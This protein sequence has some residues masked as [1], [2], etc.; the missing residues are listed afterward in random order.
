MKPNRICFNFFLIGILTISTGL[1]ASDSSSFKDQLTDSSYKLICEGY[2]NN[3][4]EIFIMDA[5][6]ANLK[7]LT[8]TPD[9]H[10]LYPQV[11]AD[12]KKIAYV[13]DK[14]K[15]RTRIRS[16]WI[17]DINGKNRI[18][19]ADYAR[20]PFWMPDNKELGFLNQEYKKFNVMDFATKGIMFYNLKIEKV[21]AHPN[22]ANIKHIYNPGFSPDSKWITATVHA[23][24]GLKHGDLL[25]EADGDKVI[26]LKIKGCRPCFSPDGKWLAWG[27]TDHVI[28]V[29]PM[30]WTKKLPSIGKPV[31]KIT[32][33][34]YK[35]YH[36][37]WA[38]NGKWLT[39]SCGPKG[40]GDITKPGTL[41]AAAEV[42]GVYAADWN[43]L[44]VKFKASS[45]VDLTKDPEGVNWIHL[46][47]N[48]KSYK[49]SDWIPVKQ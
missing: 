7:N 11:S 30:H 25:I 22:N 18:K 1:L 37:D 45:T 16:V 3:N 6:G 46:T 48:G 4:W 12:G 24:M 41:N 39:I 17:M 2:E 32:H 27:M 43:I 35:I 13:S 14:G 29:V 5:D 8:R 23:G 44:A 15:G 42:V 31:F 49:E 26:N 20:Q 10:E 19:I 36:V 21:R 9:I 47:Q 28:A 40:K 34:K 33:N 38:P